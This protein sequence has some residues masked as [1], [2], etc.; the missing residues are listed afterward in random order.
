MAAILKRVV[1]EATE[2]LQRINDEEASHRPNPHKW[3][4]KEIIGHLI[5]SAC[6]NHGRFVLAI[7]QQDLIFDGYD[8]ELWVSRQNYQETVWVD[9]VMLWQHYNLHLAHVIQG[10]P[11]E[12]LLMKRERHNLYEVAWKTVNANQPTSLGY[13]LMDYIGHLEHHLAQVL[14]PYQK[15][16]PKY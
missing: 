1:L 10:I 6:N 4:K 2:R 15:L 16:A 12:K 11:D 7:G 9:L 5:D 8:Q 3:S 13:F 14:Q